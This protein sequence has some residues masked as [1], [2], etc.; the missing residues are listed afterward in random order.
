MTCGLYNSCKLNSN[1]LVRRKKDLIKGRCD[2]TEK[3]LVIH[4]F[5][6]N[7]WTMITN[8][9]IVGVSIWPFGVLPFTLAPLPT[10]NNCCPMGWHGY[11]IMLMKKIWSNILL[12]FEE[13]SQAI[14]CPYN[15][16]VHPRF[17]PG[18]KSGNH[19]LNWK[20]WEPWI[21]EWSDNL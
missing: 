17:D 3:R 10:N 5:P 1:G 18:N 6:S 16:Y 8:N 15:I 13:S 12:V 9:K 19:V 11:D 4:E 21:S 2:H 14:S 7:K 20:N